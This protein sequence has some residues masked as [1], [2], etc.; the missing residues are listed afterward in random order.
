MNFAQYLSFIKDNM[1]LYKIPLIV[2]FQFSYYFFLFLYYFTL[3][4]FSV[5]FLEEGF[6]GF[7][8]GV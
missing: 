8:Y 7:G 2:F 1:A 3:E 4:V 5:L 6:L